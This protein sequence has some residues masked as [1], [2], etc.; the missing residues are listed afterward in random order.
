MYWVVKL[1]KRDEIKLC[2]PAYLLAFRLQFLTDRLDNRS[3]NDYHTHVTKS[4]TIAN[5]ARNQGFAMNG[6]TG[7][8]GVRGVEAMDRQV[9]QGESWYRA[10]AL[11][12]RI[13]SL[14][15]VCK[16]EFDRKLADRRLQRWRS[17]Y[18]LTKDTF[19]DTKLA[20]EGITEAEFQ[21]LLGEPVSTLAKRHGKPLTW[22]E[23][24]DRAFTMG[25]RVSVAEQD[26][27]DSEGFTIA[28]APLLA[29]GKNLLQQGIA[30]LV[31]DR[32]T[33][34]LPFDLTPIAIV[35][36]VATQDISKVQI[37]QEAKVKDCQQGKVQLRISAYPYPD[38]GTLKGA[39]REISPD[40]IAPTNADT[41]AAYYQVKIEVEKPSST[42]RQSFK[43]PPKKH[44]TQENYTTNN[45]HQTQQQSH[46]KQPISL[47][48]NRFRRTQMSIQQFYI[49]DI[50]LPTHIQ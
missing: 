46:H 14:G 29:Q 49:L 7:F 42:P 31:K 20:L 35:T 15:A 5:F 9:F 28:I 25:D 38:Y 12:E 40:A 32:K 4:S 48:P 2:L 45:Q 6:G 16:D 36:R 37:C 33:S 24:L 41:S 44:H 26:R 17:Q 23:E 1:V 43:H 10:I 22:L 30:A 34:S 11:S 8:Q 13:A 39:V 27:A 47:F 19:F 3:D 50:S 18:P 21:Y